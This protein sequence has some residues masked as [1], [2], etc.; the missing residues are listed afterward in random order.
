MRKEEER[1]I[2][3]EQDRIGDSIANE[4]D[5]WSPDG[6]QRILVRAVNNLH[7]RVLNVDA[8]DAEGFSRLWK[9]LLSANLTA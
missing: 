1:I 7:H 6:V 4:L 5:G 3:R 2:L 9:A 8:S